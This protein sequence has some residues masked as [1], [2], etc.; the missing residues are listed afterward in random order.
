MEKGVPIQKTALYLDIKPS[1]VINYYSSS[2]LYDASQS[3]S[4]LRRLSMVHSLLPLKRAGC[5]VLNLCNALIV[6]RG[7]ISGRYSL[8]Y[9]TKAAVGAPPVLT[10]GMILLLS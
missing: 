9:A 10:S 7:K 1:F 6:A 2:S 4:F 3:I 5:A 8:K